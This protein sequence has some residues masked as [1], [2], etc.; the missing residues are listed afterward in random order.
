MLSSVQ[1][2]DGV[3]ELL[4][5]FTQAPSTAESS[6]MKPETHDNGLPKPD[7]KP[8]NPPQHNGKSPAF[9]PPRGKGRIYRNTITNHLLFHRMEANCLVFLHLDP[10]K[11]NRLEKTR[12]KAV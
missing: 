1:C 8:L 9:P 10:V 7:S 2:G 4:P 12:N 11:S 6:S 5:D 3:C